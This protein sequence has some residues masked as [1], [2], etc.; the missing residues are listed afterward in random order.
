[1]LVIVRPVDLRIG[2]KSFISLGAH[3][4]QLAHHYFDVLT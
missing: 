2:L 3:M 4:V 1:M